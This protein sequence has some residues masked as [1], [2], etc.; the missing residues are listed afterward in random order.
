VRLSRPD[1]AAGPID[2]AAFAA[3]MGSFAPFESEPCIAAAVSG[4][5]DSMALIL[6]LDRWAKARGGSALALTV[7]HGLRPESGAEAARVGGWLGTWGIP[8]IILPWQGPKP[9]TGLQEAARG[10][11]YELLAEACRARGILHLA[12]AHHRDDQAETVLFRVERGSGASGLAG[13]SAS[14]SLGAARLIRPLLAWPK[15]ALVATCRSAGQEFIEDPSNRASRFA[16]TALRDRL[17]ADPKLYAELLATGHRAGL[18]R[19]AAEVG[20]AESLA[21]IAEPRPDGAAIVDLAAADPGARPDVLSAALRMVGGVAYSPDRDAVT[22]LI[23]K[24]EATGFRGAS[25]AGC[26]VRRFRGALLVAREPG[27]VAPPLELSPGR[28]TRWDNRFALRIEPSA[29][30]RFEVSALGAA[31]Y[32][33]LRRRTRSTKPALIAQTLPAISMDGRLMAVPSL[34][35]ADREA[36]RIDQYTATLWPLAPERFTVVYTDARIICHTEDAR[37]AVDRLS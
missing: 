20:L 2:D 6:L 17:E 25:L 21:R 37:P 23:R 28:W 27:R 8:H 1:P 5:P 12:A 15:P 7:D 16:R 36:P 35:W 34:G 24:S 18:D 26:L 29:Q 4:G 32:S 14:R 19:M 30:G 22:A 11:R 10:A 9:A 13:M 33:E 31:R 3:A